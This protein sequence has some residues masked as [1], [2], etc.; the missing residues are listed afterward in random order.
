MQQVIIRHAIELLD[1]QHGERRAGIGVLRREQEEA[2]ILQAR[3]QG[4]VGR[5]VEQRVLRRVIEHHGDHLRRQPGLARIARHE[6]FHGIRRSDEVV[7]PVVTLV[8][9][10][11]L[12]LEARGHFGHERRE[13]HVVIPAV[14]AVAVHELVVVRLG[15][16]VTRQ[17][18]LARAA[19]NHVV[20]FATR[21]EVITGVSEEQIRVRPA[22]EPVIPR[23]T[24]DLQLGQHAA[25][26]QVAGLE[27]PL[28]VAIGDEVCWIAVEHVVARAQVHDHVLDL[29]GLVVE[30]ELREHCFAHALLAALEAEH[31][32]T[33]RARTIRGGIQRL[34]LRQLGRE[35]HQPA[36]VRADRHAIREV[37]HQQ[38][39]LIRR[40]AHGHDDVLGEVAVG[41][42]RRIHRHRDAV[43]HTT[44]HQSE[45]NIRAELAGHWRAV[46]ADQGEARQHFG[47]ELLVRRVPDERGE[48]V[49]V[50]DAVVA[51]GGE[52]RN[53]AGEVVEVT[54]DEQHAVVAVAAEHLV[55]GGRDVGLVGIIG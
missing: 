28:L 30:V 17:Q 50:Q 15:R 7:V 48:L 25:L 38:G 22:E 32:A 53:R 18:V 41:G 20:P 40:R 54:A 31:C 42:V 2:R 52:V 51:N 29:A 6:L 39:R 9:R 49:T 5:V 43:F 11:P 37:F 10:E 8:E 35:E 23:P 16:R 44:Q 3:E 19:I 34:G 45:G 33:R 36:L 14:H 46:L 12:D 13:V 4:G 1:R 24:T 55:H 26:L 27:A 47:L 21:D